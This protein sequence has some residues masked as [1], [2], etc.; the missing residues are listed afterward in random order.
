MTGRAARGARR[1]LAAG[2]VLVVAALSPVAGT[3]A[4]FSDTALV[5]STAS[6]TLSAAPTLTCTRV[7]SNARITWTQPPTSTTYAPVTYTATVKRGSGSA[8][9][10]PV[11][12]APNHAVDVI[13]EIQ[14]ASTLPIVVTVTG[15]LPGTSWTGTTTITLT[16]YGL[17]NG[18]RIECP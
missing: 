5:S 9:A 14:L 17:L 1:V 12:T 8:A 3:R 10:A 15:T 13:G 4:A 6:S 7:G 11:G 16:M 2:A 18:W